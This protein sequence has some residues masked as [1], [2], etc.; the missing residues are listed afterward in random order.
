ME[1]ERLIYLL[2][3]DG[4]GVPM[5]GSIQLGDKDIHSQ[6]TDFFEV[7]LHYDRVLAKINNSE[8][9][10]G[11][12]PMLNLL[13][14]MTRIR[15]HTND[16]YKEVF[17]VGT[18][19]LFQKASTYADPTPVKNKIMTWEMGILDLESK[20][21]NTEQM[22]IKTMQRNH[23][24]IIPKFIEAMDI[25]I[26]T[27]TTKI[28]PAFFYKTVFSVANTGGAYNENFGLLRNVEIDPIMLANYDDGAIAGSKNSAIRNHYRAI[29]TPST[30]IGKLGITP[31]DIDD[32]KK[33]LYNYTDNGNKQ[34]VAITSSNV[35]TTLAGFYQY[36][37]TKDH[38]LSEGIPTVKINGIHFVEADN[39]I[40]EDFIF[41]AVY[42]TVETGA[43][44]TK[45]I[46]PD[47]KY[48][49][50]YMDIEGANFGWES[51]NDFNVAEV[52]VKVGEMDVHLTGR[53]RGLWLDCGN[54]PQTDGLMT[55][56]GLNILKRKQAQYKA[57]LNALIKE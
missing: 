30:V 25:V 13:T 38:F 26:S 10:N 57:Q 53:Y 33:Y 42:D 55:N 31:N 24:P 14:R 20:V 39:I 17:S 46:N 45:V 18:Q 49:G 50:L 40:P 23:I 8:A 54:R 27:Y 41:F 9:I 35:I 15:T 48:Q 51:V 37:P 1:K 44:F 43:L 2:L 4:A 36:L 21:M 28:Y 56:D 52:K 5:T 16:Y 19:A 3:N 12:T 11:T 32:V 29:K 22:E 47:P 34:I 6:M 7:G